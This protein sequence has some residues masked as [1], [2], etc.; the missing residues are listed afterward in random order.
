MPQRRAQKIDSS[1]QLDLFAGL[2][3]AGPS[4]DEV[5]EN[6]GDSIVEGDANERVEKSLKVA[7]VAAYATMLRTEQRDT[8]L[9]NGP[10]EGY[11]HVGV[12]QTFAPTFT[13]DIASFGRESYRLHQASPSQYTPSC[14][15]TVPDR[16]IDSTANSTA[17]LPPKATRKRGGKSSHK[18]RSEASKGQ[19]GS[20][21]WADKCMYAELL[22]MSGDASWPNTNND[23]LESGEHH[24]LD[25]ETADGLP[26]DLATGWVA[27]GPVPVGKRCLAVT[28]NQS[29]G[30]AGVGM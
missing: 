20:S 25:G 18:R 7:S 17:N 22:E 13:P 15:V 3:L 26:R 9:R 28:H 14:S 4:D 16:D 27:V 10:F 30:I 23:G 8:A 5:E 11:A 2:S 1:R 12:S 24:N 21:K 6:G 29:S 19:R